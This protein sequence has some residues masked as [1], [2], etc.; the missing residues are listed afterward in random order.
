[1]IHGAPQVLFLPIDLEEDFVQVPRIARAGAA[2]P[3]LVRV[4]LPELPTPLQ[5]G[6]VGHHYAAFGQQ[7]FYITVAEVEA[8][9]EPHRVRDDFLGEPK[10]G[11]G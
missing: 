4:R 6:L 9:V 7:F 10:A 11:V 5:H 8:K 2:P 1:M 3:Q